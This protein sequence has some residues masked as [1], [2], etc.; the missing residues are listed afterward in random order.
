MIRIIAS[1]FLLLYT[2]HADY[3][4]IEKENIFTIK[5]NDITF[6]ELYLNL[7]D[8]I[9]FQSYVIVHELNLAKSTK[10]IAQALDKKAVVKNGVNLLICK[11]SFTLEMHEENVHNMTFCPMVI[12]VYEDKFS[13]YISFRKYHPLKEG[14][15]MYKKINSKLK[16]VILNSLN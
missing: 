14:D 7:K 4:V 15:M 8:E 6:K 3:E 2:V 10:S 16:K 11:S 5:T 1:L 9:N 13:N 12:S